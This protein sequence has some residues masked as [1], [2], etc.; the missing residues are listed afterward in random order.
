MW[1]RLC[2]DIVKEHTRL[3]CKASEVEAL[4]ARAEFNCSNLDAGPDFAKASS[5]QAAH[6]PVRG[7]AHA[8][9]ASPSANL[10]L[11]AGHAS[12]VGRCDLSC[13]EAV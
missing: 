4:L 1:R 2:R 5:R 3:A 11:R 9:A 8:E 10:R 7:D 12:I 6:A 13:I